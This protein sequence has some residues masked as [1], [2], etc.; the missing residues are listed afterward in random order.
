MHFT[1]RLTERKVRF[2]GKGCGACILVLLVGTVYLFDLVTQICVDVSGN[3]ELSPDRLLRH[4]REVNDECN[5]TLTVSGNGGTISSPGYPEKYPSNTDCRW[6]LVSE[7]PNAT[8]FLRIDTLQIEPDTNCKLDYLQVH[9]GS[10]TLAPALDPLCG[11]IKDRVI[12]TNSSTL[13]VVFH[14]DPVYEDRGFSVDYFTQS[15][16]DCKTSLTGSSGVIRSPGFPNNYPDKTDCWT[17]ITVKEDKKIALHFDSLDLE[18]GDNCTFDYVQIY[19][20]AT[21]E[22]RLLAQVCSRQDISHY[23]STANNL[24][25]HF[26]SDESVN[27]KGYRAQYSAI[28]KRTLVTGDCLWESGDNNGTIAS[29]NYPAHYPSSSNCSIWLQAPEDQKIFIQFDALQLEIEVNCSYDFLQINDGPPPDS[30]SMGR[31]C[32]KNSDPKNLTSATNEVEILFH[33][34]DFAEFSGF[35]LRYMF[36]KNESESTPEQAIIK[37]INGKFSFD[38]IPNNATLSIGSSHMLRCN[39]RHPLAKIRWLKDDHFLAGGSPMPGLKV[40]NNNTLWIKSMDHHLAGR[41]TCAMVTPEETIS[42]DAYILVES[43]AKRNE[44]SCGIVFRKIPRDISYAEG[45]FA[46]LE[47][48][49]SG[50][51]VQISWEKDG[52]PLKNDGNRVTI[53]PNGFIFLPKV[54][55]SDAGVYSCVAYDNVA[56]CQ[57]KESAFLQIIERAPID[58]ICGKPKVGM[59][60]KDIPLMEHGKIVGGHNTK[61]GAYPWQ[62]MLWEPTLKSFCGG[63]LLNER[64]IATAAHCFI[65]YKGLRWD[66]IVIKLGKHDREHEEEEE[67]RTGIADPSSI[68]VHPAY[69]KVTFDNDLALVRLRDHVHF[70]DYILPVC[71]GDRDL[72]EKFLAG[73]SGGSPIYMGTVTGWGKLKEFGPSPRYLQEI[74][75]PIVDQK[76]CLASTNYTVSRNMFCA[77]YAQEILGDACHGDSGGPFLMPHRERWYLVGIVSWGEGCGKANKYGFYTRIPNYLPW[78]KGIMKS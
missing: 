9:L 7:D 52:Q 34:D 10:S 37:Q 2:W 72:G 77:G 35:K 39:T 70:S 68:V 24:L 15:A 66:R 22:S 40:L 16:G 49:A 61:K 57:K 74:R 48:L 64:W 11:N 23:E 28:G 3:G 47:C 31:F 67:F 41:Y 33:S 59:P 45:E 63:S 50:T 8:L 78:I 18:Y 69:N 14:S 20:G 13:L 65:N 58:E 71:L 54:A 60:S 38:T 42:V 46:H 55:L 4:A 62:V 73:S 29:P 36:M 53:L 51:H 27:R 21:R 56:N 1:F 17:L 26:H 5:L 32:G 19:D 43:G 75:L 76:I 30:K 44:S 12:K 25:I 6:L